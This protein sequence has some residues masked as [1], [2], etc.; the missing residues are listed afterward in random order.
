MVHA[1][2]YRYIPLAFCLPQ[3]SVVEEEV[4]ERAEAGAE[5]PQAVTAVLLPDDAR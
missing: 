2:R 1:C 3:D 5:G 4:E